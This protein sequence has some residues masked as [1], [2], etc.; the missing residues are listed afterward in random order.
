MTVKTPIG[1]LII[2]ALFC[3]PS[4][5]QLIGAI[6]GFVKEAPGALAYFY[7]GSMAALMGALI[8]MHVSTIYL[9]KNTPQLRPHNGER[10]SYQRLLFGMSGM[11]LGG[12][13]YMLLTFHEMLHICATDPFRGLMIHAL[14]IFFA[15]FTLWAKTEHYNRM[16][17]QVDGVGDFLGDELNA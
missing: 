17:D 10:Y 14:W 6:S 5:V 15:S 7:L 8:W 2:L 9:T 16:K 13:V 12:I 4:A 1:L 3:I 11:C